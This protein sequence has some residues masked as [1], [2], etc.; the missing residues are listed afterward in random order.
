MVYLLRKQSSIQE[1]FWSETEQIQCTVLLLYFKNVCFPFE[2]IRNTIELNDKHIKAGTG[3]KC[4][5]TSLSEAQTALRWE[6]G[7]TDSQD[8][9]ARDLLSRNLNPGWGCLSL[10]SASSQKPK[11]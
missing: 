10:S 1:L 3:N 5:G 6:T 2:M 8:F 9:P 7:Q 11:L 4:S